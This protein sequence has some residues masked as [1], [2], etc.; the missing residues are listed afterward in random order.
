MD[1][2][3]INLVKRLDKFNNALYVD[4]K[5]LFTLMEV[6]IE[7]GILTLDDFNKAKEGATKDMENKVKN[8]K[9]TS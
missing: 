3:L 5:T 9:K 2:N 8:E 1:K 6:L 4:M 7:K